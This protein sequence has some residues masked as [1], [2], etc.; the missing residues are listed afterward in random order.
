MIGD[1]VKGIDKIDL[2]FVDAKTSVGN[3]GNQDFSFSGGNAFSAEGQIR[4]FTEGG[5]TIVQVNNDGD[6]LAE[7]E[8]Q[9]T[10]NIN[11]AAV[12]LHPLIQPAFRFDS[13]SSTGRVSRP[14]IFCS[15]T[16]TRRVA[17]LKQFSSCAEIIPKY[18]SAI[19]WSV[20]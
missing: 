20:I 11:L 1:F 17:Q 19:D 8:I 18:S 10:G 12:R 6:L 3:L 5:N 7:G 2:H 14:V 9:L 4:V 13:P 15:E 16:G